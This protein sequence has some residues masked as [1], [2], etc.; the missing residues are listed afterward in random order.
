MDQHW[1]QSCEIYNPETDT[2]NYTGFLNIGRMY[3][4]ITLLPNGNVLAVRTE[5]GGS[6]VTLLIVDEDADVDIPSGRIAT[7]YGDYW[8]LEDYHGGAPTADGYVLV[9]INGATYHLLAYAP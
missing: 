7:G 6:E 4:E 8:D 5:R 1:S 9:D 2:W 3:P